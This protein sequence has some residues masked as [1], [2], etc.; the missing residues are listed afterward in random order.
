MIFYVNETEVGRAADE[1]L[2]Q[3]D[4]GLVAE[5]FAPGGL[6]VHFDDFSVTPLAE[7]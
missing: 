6:R 2:T 5:T 4:I 7:N 1:T 3:G